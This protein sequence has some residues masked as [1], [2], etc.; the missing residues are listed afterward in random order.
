MELIDYYVIESVVDYDND[1]LKIGRIKCTIPGVV[2]AGSTPEEGMPWIR[3]F[4]MG[5]Y[6]TFTRPIKGQKVW[7]LISKTNYNEFWWFPFHEAIDITKDY[8]EEYYDENCDVFHARHSGAGDCMMTYDD[9]QGYVTKIGDDHINLTPR[10]ECEI[11]A[12]SMTME[13]KDNQ[14]HLGKQGGPWSQV[15]IWQLTQ[16]FLNK[17]AGYFAE[18]ATCATKTGICAD[19]AGPFGGLA[20]TCT[21]AELFSPDTYAS[22]T[23]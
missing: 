1:P 5:G 8:I 18:L 23:L 4:K 14:V 12:N 21:E 19:M 7:V 20:S 13:I 22:N 16:Q 6:Q 2:H 15:V 10:R 17:C 11:N 3:C 9:E